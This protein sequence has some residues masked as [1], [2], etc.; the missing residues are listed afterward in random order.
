M[1]RQGSGGYVKKIQVYMQENKDFHFGWSFF[2]GDGERGLDGCQYQILIDPCN[3]LKNLCTNFGND[4]SQR[5]GG[6]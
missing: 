2:W 4:R 5:L 6:V 3:G 1:M